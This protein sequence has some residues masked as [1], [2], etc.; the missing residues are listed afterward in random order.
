MRVFFFGMTGSFS[1]PPL[2]ALLG[3]GVDVCAVIIPAPPNAR[4]GGPALARVQPSQNSLLPILNPFLEQSSISIAWERGIPVFEVQ[5]LGAS[6]TLAA[7]AS[8][9]A[10]VA[11]VACF[12]RRIPEALLALPRHGFLNIH[13]ALLPAHR[14]PEP[15]FWVM[16]S[17]DQ[18]GV[19][20]HWMDHGLDTGDIAAQTPLD[21]PDGISGAEAE[22]Q[23]AEAGGLLLVDVLDRLAHDQVMRTP[24][25]PTGAYE[26]A[27]AA[28]DFMLDT[29][30]SARRAFN[31][32]R[33]TAEWEHPYHVDAGGAHLELVE[34]IWYDPQS[35]LEQPFVH[36]GD[37]IQIQFTPGVL[38]AHRH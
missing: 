22:Y 14:G 27:P 37:Q 7:L 20:I 6:E 5:R 35:H 32:M 25:P 10:D 34:A 21:L 19:T 24:Q 3:A 9:Q 1:R 13:P 4:P 17:G 2:E 30:W 26:P 23:C 18:P 8:F 11:C 29:G 33:A 36:T 16:R 31:F 12:S 15:L 38:C 28:Q